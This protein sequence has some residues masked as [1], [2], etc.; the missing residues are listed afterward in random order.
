MIDLKKLF[1][2]ISWKIKGVSVYA[3]VGES[4]TGKSFRAQ[5][6]A[7]KYGIKLIIDDGLLIYNDK[8]I[9]GQSAKREKTF[10]LNNIEKITIEKTKGGYDLVL[11]IKNDIE[12][13]SIWTGWYTSDL[14]LIR[15]IILEYKVKGEE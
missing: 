7:E 9:A 4:G 6:L 13:R 3:L 2:K 1:K 11:K 5:L 8:I 10:L 15:K 14:R 12:D